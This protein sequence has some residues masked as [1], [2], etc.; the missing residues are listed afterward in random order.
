MKC[1]FFVVLRASAYTT[2]GR[3]HTVFIHIIFAVLIFL[4]FVHIARTS[5]KAKTIVT[6]NGNTTVSVLEI[7]ASKERLPAKSGDFR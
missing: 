6:G 7:R 2:V 3:L 5:E 4:W 1:N